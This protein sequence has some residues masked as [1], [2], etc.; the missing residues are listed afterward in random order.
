MPPLSE[1]SG[2]AHGEGRGLFAMSQALGTLVSVKTKS[3]ARDLCSYQEFKLLNVKTN[4]PTPGYTN[5]VTLTHIGLSFTW[6]WVVL[7]REVTPHPLQGQGC[8]RALRAALGC[9][10]SPGPAHSRASVGFGGL[11]CGSWDSS[12]PSA[13]IPTGEEGSQLRPGP[14]AQGGGRQ[15]GTPA[16]PTAPS[17]PPP[18][19]APEALKHLFSGCKAVFLSPL[20]LTRDVFSFFLEAELRTDNSASGKRG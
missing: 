9:R 14:W 15:L 6:V 5:A 1:H 17:L 20:S 12:E 4:R 13:A 19:K 7:G 11:G 16:L 10:I 2:W 3:E 8:Y 18:A